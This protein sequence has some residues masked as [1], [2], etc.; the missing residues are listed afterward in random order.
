MKAWA[1][2]VAAGIPDDLYWRLTPPEIAALLD[3]IH[4][5]EKK[6]NRHG[7]LRAGLVAATIENTNPYRRKGTPLKQPE[8]Y[9]REGRQFEPFTDEELARLAPRE[10][11]SRSI[12][13]RKR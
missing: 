10:R 5:R 7:I 1:Y 6:Q 11:P 12:R 2:C 3:A 8:D 9:L 4:E 13:K